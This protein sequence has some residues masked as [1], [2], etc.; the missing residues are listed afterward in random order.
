MRTMAGWKIERERTRRR[1]SRV[2]WWY[3]GFDWDVG[4]GMLGVSRG[5]E[6]GRVVVIYPG[7]CQRLVTFGFI[8]VEQPWSFTRTSSLGD[9]IAGWMSR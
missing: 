3:Q 2:R 9:C 8:Q 1:R 4:W 5:Y 6:G 7:V